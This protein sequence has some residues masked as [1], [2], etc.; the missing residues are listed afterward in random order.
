MT[1]ATRKKAAKKKAPAKRSSKRVAK[2]GARPKRGGTFRLPDLL[3]NPVL[4]SVGAF[5]LAE[6][7]LERLVKELIDRG[8]TSERE[9]RKLV[10]DYRKRATRARSDFDKTVDTRIADALGSF[11]LPTKKD[12]DDL[13]RKINMLERRVDKLV[14]RRRKS[15]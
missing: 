7:G 2:K 5:S 4:A 12:M 3:R 8:E 14:S 11:R 6:E 10:E 15:G 13:H 1:V 9:G